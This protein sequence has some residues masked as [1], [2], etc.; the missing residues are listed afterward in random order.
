M[1][2]FEFSDEK[3]L[4]SSKYGEI[5]MQWN[6]MHS[7]REG[8]TAFILTPT[9]KDECIIARRNFVTDKQMKDFLALL[10]SNVDASK[11]ILKKYPFVQPR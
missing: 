4:V 6:E 11:R 5:S 1:T 7:V 3:I 8:K 2:H 9:G 10:E